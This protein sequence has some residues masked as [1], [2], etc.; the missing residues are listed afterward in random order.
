MAV[1][2]ASVSTVSIRRSR[3]ASADGLSA[4][5]AAKVKPQIDAEAP[6]D[7][8]PKNLD[9]DRLAALGRDDLGAVHLRNGSRGDGGSKR[10]E[11]VLERLA[12]RR[13]NGGF[14]IGLRERRHLVLQRLQVARQRKPDHIRPRRQELAELDI[15]RP[16]LGERGRQ[17]IFH[18]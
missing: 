13:R 3:R 5:R 18:A 1:E 14:G 2:A 12:Q 8:G 9:R 7:A 15:G 6:L 17:A 4:W 16:K 11:R 10:R